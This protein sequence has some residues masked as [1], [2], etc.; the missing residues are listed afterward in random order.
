M[1][2][3]EHLKV[4]LTMKSTDK[5]SESHSY[6]YGSELGTAIF[7]L[8]AD[9]CCELLRKLDSIYLIRIISE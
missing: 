2:F 1:F 8:I 5:D 4:L 6:I 3:I 9:N 7:H